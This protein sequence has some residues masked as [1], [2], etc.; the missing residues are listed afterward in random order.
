MKGSGIMPPKASLHKMKMID[1]V[2]EHY[3]KELKDAS[4]FNMALGS[5]IAC[6]SILNMIGEGAGIPAIKEFCE[7]NL[8][9][10]HTFKENKKNEEEKKK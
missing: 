6:N 2:V 8:K 3:T 9:L 10:A 4:V 1:S 5:E 7:L